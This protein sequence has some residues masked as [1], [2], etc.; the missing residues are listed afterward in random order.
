[1]EKHPKT[2]LVVMAEAA[3][4]NRLVADALRL[5]A[6]G[7]TVH[8]VRGGGRMGRREALW[9]ADR[10]IELQ[11]ICDADVADAIARHY[12]HSYTPDYAL[13]LYFSPV[14]V[15]RAEKF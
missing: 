4:E 6:L 5:G 10:S 14:H 3:L 7:Y 9:E 13:S 8:D 12:L 15:V 1:M 2:L 11:V